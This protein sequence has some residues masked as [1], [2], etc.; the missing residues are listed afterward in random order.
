[1][2]L[3]F[4]L[5][6]FVPLT[7]L[8]ALLLC[9]CSKSLILWDKELIKVVFDS[10][11]ELYQVGLGLKIAFKMTPRLALNAA[12]ILVQRARATES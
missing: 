2:A 5:S 8:F 12:L 10:E 7:Q 1:M 11:R 9:G 3:L 6:L 4:L